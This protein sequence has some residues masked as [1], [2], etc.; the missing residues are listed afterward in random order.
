[1]REGVSELVGEYMYVSEWVTEMVGRLVG[2]WV[3]GYS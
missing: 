3:A 2:A 1:M